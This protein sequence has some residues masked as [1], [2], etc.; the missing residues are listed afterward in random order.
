MCLPSI[1]SGLSG[2]N[3]AGNEMRQMSEFSAFHSKW[4]SRS[5]RQALIQL[6]LMTRTSCSAQIKNV[7]KY[8]SKQKS[9]TNKHLLKP[10]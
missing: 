10:N 5:E 9:N 6:L 2:A 4:T 3:W 8:V 7:L 1:A